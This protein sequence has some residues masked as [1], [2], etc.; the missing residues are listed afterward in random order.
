VDRW[1][2]RLEEHET[3]K[4]YGQQR[5]WNKGFLIRPKGAAV[6]GLA[7]P[8]AM[9]HLNDLPTLLLRQRQFLWEKL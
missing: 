4:K 9:S 6:S 7:L 1:A 3:H 8:M 5:K 2:V